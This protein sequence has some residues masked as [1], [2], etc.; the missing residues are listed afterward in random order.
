MNKNDTTEGTELLR[1]LPDMRP[2]EDAWQKILRTQR[3]RM[4]LVWSGAALAACAAL[5][6]IVLITRDDAPA[7]PVETFVVS[8]DSSAT[9]TTPLQ[10]RIAGTKQSLNV[11]ELRRRSRQ[12]ERML[13][14]LPSRNEVIRADVAGVVSELQD[15]I[16]AVDYELNRQ[17]QGVPSQSAT[18]RWP[19][20][21]PAATRAV[22]RSMPA[23]PRDLW[24]Q[25]VELMDQLVRVR[26]V[27]AGA[28]AH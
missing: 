23:G 28:E 22:A 2:P 15:R 11:A 16:A 7:A 17:T 6:A 10:V 26:Y 4:P 13:S 27:E 5:V 12:M 21:Q 18:V 20:A 9:R 8:D 14:G 19:S 24:R 1:S 3:R 25:R